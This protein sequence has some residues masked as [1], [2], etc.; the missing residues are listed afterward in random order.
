MCCA[1]VNARC[2]E[3]DKQDNLTQIHNK[4]RLFSHKAHFTP[5]GQF[6]HQTSEWRAFCKLVLESVWC[7][8]SVELLYFN[9]KTIKKQHYHFCSFLFNFI[10]IFFNTVLNFWVVCSRSD[11][12]LRLTLP[13]SPPEASP[14]HWWATQCRLPQPGAGRFI[15]RLNLPSMSPEWLRSWWVTTFLWHWICH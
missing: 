5:K 15:L 9:L 8:I 10:F 6:T 14:V 1:A 3:R 11:T 7:L 13:P 4:I 12:W 2:F